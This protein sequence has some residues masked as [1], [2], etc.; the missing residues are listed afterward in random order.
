M[1]LAA[2]PSV[3]CAVMFSPAEL[4]LPCHFCLFLKQ[5]F[6]ACFCCEFPACPRFCL[7]WQVESAFPGMFIFRAQPSGDKGDDRGFGTSVLLPDAAERPW[8]GHAQSGAKLTFCPQQPRGSDRQGILFR[9]GRWLL[10]SVSLVPGSTEPGSPS[11][12]A[13]EGSLR[14]LFP[15]G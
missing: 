9:A 11:P 14:P 1:L 2:H 13:A 5:T 10:S 6:L 15:A 4:A 3:V 12:A 8:H 7:C